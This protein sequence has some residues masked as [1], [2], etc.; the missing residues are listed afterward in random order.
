[1]KLNTGQVFTVRIVSWDQRSSWLMPDLQQSKTQE[2]WCFI[3]SRSDS[4]EK[5]NKSWCEGFTEHE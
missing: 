3:F 4:V 5:A 2:D 1:M